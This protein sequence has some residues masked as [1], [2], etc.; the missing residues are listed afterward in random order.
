MPVNVALSVIAMIERAFAPNSAVA[1]REMVRLLNRLLPR[2]EL[3]VETLVRR[4]VATPPRASGTMRRARSSPPKRRLP[5]LIMIR[6][7]GPTKT[8][9]DCQLNMFLQFHFL[10]RGPPGKTERVLNEKG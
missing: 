8:N 7:D 9:F 1:H 3:R 4:V 10:Y 5:K 2:P 6:T